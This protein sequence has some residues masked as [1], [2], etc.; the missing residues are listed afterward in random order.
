VPGWFRKVNKEVLFN[1]NCGTITDYFR[2]TAH[3]LSSIIPDAYHSIPANL[4]SMLDHEFE[5]IS[6][7]FF[8]K[9]GIQGDIPPGQRLKSGSNIAEYRS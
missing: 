2:H 7:R 4:L 8:A 5:S 1:R 3:H 9:F 6:A